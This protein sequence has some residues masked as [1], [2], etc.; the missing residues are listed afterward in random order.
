MID[1]LHLDRGGHRT[2]LKW[3]RARRRAGDPAFTRS[4][5]LEGMRLGASVEIDLVLHGGH[6][7]AVL[8]DFLLDEGTTGHGAVR[9]TPPEVLRGLRL[10]WDDGT[11]RADTVML[12]DDLC[13]LLVESP[14]APGALL[15]LAVKEDHSAL[16]ALTVT[17]FA[18]TV[19][20]VATSMIVS[21]GDAAAIA[22][23]AGATPGLTLG[24]DPC[25]DDRLARLRDTRDFAGF[26]D[27]GLAEAPTA[28]MIY[29]AHEIIAA[30]DV[31]GFDLIG[32]CHT[33]GKRVDAWT[34]QHVD[35]RSVA[36]CERLIALGVDQITTDDPEGLAAALSHDDLVT[37]RHDGPLTCRHDDFL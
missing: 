7:F 11:P 23:L 13:A 6:G 16:D 3:H 33:A 27:E 2:W 12:L 22:A 21:G 14:P 5:I 1:P 32:A 19:E 28:S 10:R 17:G 37:C 20:P 25:R 26:I 31:A 15:Q 34:I 18:R 9:E 35:P 29:L 4:R 36:R 8:H 24:H 30:A